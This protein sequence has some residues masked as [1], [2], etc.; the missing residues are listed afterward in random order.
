MIK[1]FIRGNTER[2]AEV[3]KA[4]EDLGGVNKYN[5]NGDDLVYI[6]FIARD[7]CITRLDYNTDYARII[8]E[9]F[10]EIKL[11]DKPVITNKQFA[12]WY[13]NQLFINSIVQYKFSDNGTI[14]SKMYDYS[15]DDFPTPVKHIRFNF[16]EWLPIE[17]VD[18]I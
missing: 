7:N 15:E 12:D 11:K 17:K 3:I 8:Q 1:K 5:L 16:G 2:G 9:C 6:Y 14:Y 10:E 13:F 4:L 18:I